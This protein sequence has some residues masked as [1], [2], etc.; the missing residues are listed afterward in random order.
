MQYASNQE[1]N[2][3]HSKVK[4]MR[5]HILILPSELNIIEI[6]PAWGIFQRRQ[7][8]ILAEAGY[9]T[10]MLCTGLLP[11]NQ[12]FKKNIYRKWTITIEKEVITARLYKKRFLPLWFVPQCFQ[13]KINIKLA[14]EAFAEY[15]KEC[16]IP[17]LIHAHNCFYAG[18]IAKQFKQTYNVPFVVTEHSS[19]FFGALGKHKKALF[20]QVLK[21]S[22]HYAAVSHKLS[23]VLMAYSIIPKKQIVIM[24]NVLDDIF[25]LN[26]IKEKD[27]TTNFI[28]F[29]AANL[30]KIK[31]HK[32]L[33]EAFALMYANKT[34]IK[35][36]I[37]G[38][39]PNKSFL[40]RLALKLHIAEQVSFLG[41]IDRNRILHEMQQCNVFVLSSNF[42][43]FG[44]SLIEALSCGIPVVSTA[45]GGPDEIV[46]KNN[47]ILVEKENEKALAG[48]LETMRLSVNKYNPLL[49]RE[50]CLSLY[51]KKAFLQNI[52]K[53]YL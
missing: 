34:E 35:L 8:Q 41:H 17:D 42:E 24:N 12:L 16:G 18:S 7:A 32:L 23:E 47:G 9:H 26:E 11:F 53:F 19:F 20:N 14:L 38:D 3:S 36:R 51:G 48:A 40:Q 4:Y 29:T 6:S 31:N 45:S 37:A 25:E 22:K 5:M 1:Y 46:N 43:T 28:F 2:N 49:I 10:G 27:Q 50:G 52:A 30:I 39:G 33:L 15:I 21:E 13:N 44:V